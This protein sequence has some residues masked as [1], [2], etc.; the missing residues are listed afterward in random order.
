MS[1][2]FIPVRRRL[3]DDIVA[4][5]E[6]SDELDQWWHRFGNPDLRKVFEHF[7]MEAF[8]RSS[9]L[10]GFSAFVSTA[11]FRGKRC[12][13]IGTC[14]GLTSLV[15]ARHFEEVV[16]IDIESDKD[17][18]SIAEFCGIKNI[19]FHDVAD[20]AEKGAVIRALGDF[21]AAYCDGNHAYDARAD[22]DLVERCGRVL[23]HE[24]WPL[25]PTVWELVN[26]LRKLG[27]VQTHSNFALWTRRNG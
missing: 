26:R 20:N 19:V 5:M 17:K 12:V 25:Q 10:D 1:S 11:E 3:K 14:K 7:G 8:R 9:C 15:L 18:Q 24:Y 2:K 16:T 21:D 4:F 22:F 13:E 6:R 27:P 23:F